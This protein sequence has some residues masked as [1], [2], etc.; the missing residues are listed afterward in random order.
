MDPRALV[1]D[2][3]AERLAGSVTGDISTRAVC[4]AAGITQPVLF[5]LFGD[6]DALLAATVDAVWDRYLAMKRAATP[7]PDPIAD[8][9]AGWDAHVAFAVANPHAYRLLFGGALAT[10]PAALAQAT[11]L[12]R[13]VVER[14][15]TAGHLAVPVDDAVRVVVAANTGHALAILRGDAA[16]AATVTA[17]VRDA[18]IRGIVTEESAM[19]ASAPGDHSDGIKPAATAAT[20][21]LAHLAGPVPI[22]AAESAL[23]A[24]WLERMQHASPTQQ[25]TPHD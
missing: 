9:K 11:D 24:E 8:L 19:E 17:A 6:K 5:R 18:T 1:L 14:I 15:A 21:L 20:T 23:F 25:E 16:F 7:S 12:L 13:S 4:E 22:S 3:T 2:K 10:R